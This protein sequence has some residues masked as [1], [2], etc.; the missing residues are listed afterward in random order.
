MQMIAAQMDMDAI[1]QQDS[2]N[3][4][5]QHPT[6]VSDGKEYYDYRKDHSL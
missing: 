6:T 2:Q 4:F 1:T 5:H 3:I